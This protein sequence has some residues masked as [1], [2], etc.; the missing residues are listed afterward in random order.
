MRPGWDAGLTTISSPIL[1][2]LLVRPNRRIVIGLGPFLSTVGRGTNGEVALCHNVLMLVDPFG[3]IAD[4]S[5]PLGFHAHA[6]AQGSYTHG[7]ETR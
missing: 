1:Y 2:A 5:R 6:T 7:L 3:G 4:L